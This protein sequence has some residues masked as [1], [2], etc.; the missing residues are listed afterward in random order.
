MNLERTI[1]RE[2]PRHRGLRDF[3]RGGVSERAAAAVEFALV[4]PVGLLLF[5]GAYIYGTVDEINR[6]ITLTARDVT[7]IVTQYSTITSGDMTAALNSSAQVMAPFST[8]GLTFVVSQVTINTAGVG[9]V[10]WCAPSCL[11]GYSVGNPTPTPLPSNI[12]GIPRATSQSS[13]T[14]IWGHAAYSYTPSIGYMVTNTFNL[15]DDVYLSP[16]V[17]S[18]ITINATSSTP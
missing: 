7:D 5:T 11:S 4:L 18:T 13:V 1:L 16:R 17:S 2:K 8:S 14:V 9:T 10:N 12:S 3:L 6:K 15:S